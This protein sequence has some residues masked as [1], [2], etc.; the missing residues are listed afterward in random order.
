VNAVTNFGP[1]E[2]VG[3]SC[4]ATQLEASREGLVPWS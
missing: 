1:H 2:M 3:G 4:I